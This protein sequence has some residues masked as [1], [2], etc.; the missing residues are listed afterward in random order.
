VLVIDGGAMSIT[1]AGQCAISSV[2]VIETLRFFNGSTMQLRSVDHDAVGDER[3][4]GQGNE[5][6][7]GSNAADSIY[8]D[9]GINL[10]WLGAGA[11]TL[12]YKQSDPSTAGSSIGGGN[13]DDR[14]V[15][16]NVAQD[17]LDFREI[18]GLRLAG[19]VLGETAAGDATVGWDSGDA[20]VSNI[21]ITLT[22]VHLAELSADVF[23]FA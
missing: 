5:V 20:S 13:V 9:A 18:R 23:L 7:F 19:L 8:T 14:I 17:H 2:N 16:F 4:G 3:S 1:I 15:D 22:G 12:I 6:I 21:S 10:V 11:D